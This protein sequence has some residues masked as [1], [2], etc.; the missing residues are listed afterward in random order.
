VRKT[1][2]THLVRLLYERLGRAIPI[3]VVRS[4]VNVV[5]D[6]IALCLVQDVPVTVKR[7]GTLSPYRYHGHPARHVGT[8]R[9]VEVKAFRTV[10]LHASEAFLELLSERKER[11]EKS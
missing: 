1:N 11:F 2:K 3:R 9:M 4:A 5:S 10:K 6:E 7:F 8:G